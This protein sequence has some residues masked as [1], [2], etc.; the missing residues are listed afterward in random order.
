MR[1]PVPSRWDWAVIGFVV[2]MTLFMLAAGAF[3]YFIV[4]M[5]ASSI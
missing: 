2:I 1:R 4:W 5:L 3:P